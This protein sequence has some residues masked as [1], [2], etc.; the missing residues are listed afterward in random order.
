MTKILV[1]NE[2]ESRVFNS[3]VEVKREFETTDRAI[4]LAI[5]DGTG[6]R[7]K[8]GK[9]YWVDELADDEDD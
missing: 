7:H 2:S 3:Y 1:N 4:R 5:K 6:L 8:N 9:V